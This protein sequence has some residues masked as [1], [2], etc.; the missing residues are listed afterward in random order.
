MFVDLY[1]YEWNEALEVLIHS[2][3]EQKAIE[4]LKDILVVSDQYNIICLP[5]E[6]GG[7]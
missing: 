6:V 4:V 1:D 5:N 7:I 2:M 3:K